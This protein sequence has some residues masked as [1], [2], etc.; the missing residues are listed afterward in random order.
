MN[1]NFIDFTLENIFSEVIPMADT[2]FNEYGVCISYSKNSNLSAF[3]PVVCEFAI[4]L[5]WLFSMVL[6][7]YFDEINDKNR[8]L[9]IHLMGKEAI[10]IISK[11]Y[12]KQAVMI[13]VMNIAEYWFIQNFPS[14][15][16]VLQEDNGVTTI[17]FD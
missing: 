17:L 15:S 2:F 12:T 13:A 6:N 16:K 11:D 3:I 5:S 14:K 1:S 8:G 9:L 10:R 7:I 4:E